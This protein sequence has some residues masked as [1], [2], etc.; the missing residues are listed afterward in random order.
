MIG[1]AACAAGAGIAAGTQPNIAQARNLC[2]T[3]S[4][5]FQRVVDMPRVTSAEW[6]GCHAGLLR[7]SHRTQCQFA[8][9]GQ[10][11]TTI[12]AEVLSRVDPRV[13]EQPGQTPLIR[14]AA[15]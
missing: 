7:Q 3:A 13:I 11:A 5:P 14:V 1:L 12:D 9:F 10:D 6:R 2:I 4:V 8:G 15:E